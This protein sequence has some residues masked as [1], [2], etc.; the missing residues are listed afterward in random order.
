MLSAVLIVLQFPRYAEAQATEKSSSASDVRFESGKSALKIP[1]KLFGGRL[2]FLQVRVNNS[3]PLWFNLDTGADSSFLSEKWVKNLG[4]KLDDKQQV[5]EPGGAVEQGTVKGISYN[6]PNVNLINQ[7]AQ[8]AELSSLEPYLGH[9]FDG[10]FGDDFLKQFVVEVDYANKIINLY[11]PKTYKYNGSGESVP[12]IL[13]NKKAYVQGEIEQ[14]GRA[15]IDAKL[16]LDTGSFDA[17]G[18]NKSFVEK[19]NLIEP[20]QKKLFE[21]GLAI[22]GETKGYRA[23]V[24]ALRIGKFRISNPVISVTTDSAGFENS[25]KSAGTLGGEI[26]YRFKV[27]FDYARRRM[28]LEKNIHFNEPS[29]FDMSGIQLISEGRNFNVIKVREVLDN[30]PASESGLLKGDIIVSVNGRAAETFTLEK[31]YLKFREREGKVFHFIIRRNG[32]LMNAEIKL[33]SLI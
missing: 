4:L 27:I 2:I 1:F 17:L 25:T 13:E 3:Q 5:A 11:D 14:P 6:L 26:F 9:E 29:V 23:R 18:L 31:L 8:T 28:I 16:E 33:R 32:K 19:T 20:S 24:A 15:P 7:T 12:I 21:S 22:G 10:F 30:S